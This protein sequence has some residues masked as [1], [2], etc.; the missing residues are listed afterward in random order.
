[1]DINQKNR[2]ISQIKHSLE[3]QK[4]EMKKGKISNNDYIRFRKTKLNI[5]QKI[6][7]DEI[8]H[9]ESD[10]DKTPIKTEQVQNKSYYQAPIVE[11]DDSEWFI[12]TFEQ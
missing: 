1:M 7:N 11:S 5:I 6:I 8:D 3:K 4:N 2:V 10:N 9:Y 12:I